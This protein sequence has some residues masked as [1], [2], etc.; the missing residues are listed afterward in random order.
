MKKK[1]ITIFIVALLASCASIAY[2]IT[3]DE[4]LN[5][6]KDGNIRFVKME[7]QHPNDKAER[8][9]DTATAGQKPFAAVLACSDSRG[10]VE[11]IFDRGIGD[12][13]VI[14]VAGNIAMDKSVIGS[15]EYAVGHLG[16]P[17]LVVMGHTECGA[18]KAAVSGPPLTG[19]IRD[20]QK[21]IEPV[22]EKVKREYPYLKGPELTTAVVKS[23]VLQTKAD[24]LSHSG[25]IKDMA[26]EGRLKIVT[27][28]Y[29]I[30]TGIVDWFE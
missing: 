17:I 18:V 23:N 3:A 1:I 28:I 2:C 11:M 15:A 4:A 6:L 29:D 24:I 10:P 26:D 27:A 25:E 12:I 13:F 14:R 9:K 20:I 21:K 7:M 5:L 22:A 8:R 16:C 30:K 19:D